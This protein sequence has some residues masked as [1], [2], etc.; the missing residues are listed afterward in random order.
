[1]NQG[2]EHNVERRRLSKLIAGGG[3]ASTLPAWPA[4]GRAAEAE[5]AYDVIV[6]GAGMAGLYAAK[7]LLQQ[8]Y[9]VRVLEATA[10]HGGRIYSR[11]LGST[12]IEMGAEEHYLARDNPIYD[13]VV[14]GYGIDV[15]TRAYV[16]EQLLTMD[17]DKTCWED[18]GSCDQDPD[19]RNFWKYQEYYGRRGKH[20]DF[21]LTMADVILERYGVGP[22][23]RAYH[24]YEH[25]IANSIYGAS[26]NRI[27]AASLAQQDWN[28]TLSSDIRVVAPA[29]LG[30]SDMLDNIWWQEVLPHVDYERPVEAIDYSGDS[31][32][33]TDATGARTHAH[34]VIVTASIGVLQSETITF[35]PPLPEATVEA[36]RAIGMGRGMKVA[37][38]FPEPFWE[39]R[40]AYLITDGPVSSAWAP[41]HYKTGSDDHILMCYPMG[42]D[43]QDLT[44]AARRAGGGAAGDAEIVR[45][46]LADLDRIFDGK[47]S[48]AIIDVQLQDWTAD[49]YVR[50]SYSFPGPE[51]YR[52]A[53][54]NMRRRLGT[55]VAERLMFAGEGSNPSN[56]ACVPGALQEGRRAAEYVHGLLG[57]VSSP[58]RIQPS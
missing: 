41:S 31:V 4:N 3:L 51:T 32:V 49:P 30:Y 10:R 20:R 23:H 22:D 52:S 12:R 27:G 25:A 47:A 24:L 57:G 56:P 39:A 15:Y 16:G 1:M 7:T 11:T 40:M 26:L 50:G 48:S 46:L 37:L 34:K 53:M 42:D 28:W 6:V 43:A 29:N 18:S 36:Y 14:D 58:P 13:A 33:V 35:N 44:D 55:P 45:A 19:I 38:R 54:D 21:S 8:G 5:K 9:R 17:G 2:S